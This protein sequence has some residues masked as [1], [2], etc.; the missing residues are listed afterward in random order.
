MSSYSA[1][2]VYV[3]SVRFAIGRD[4]FNSLSILTGQTKDFKNK[5]YSSLLDPLHE[6]HNVDKNLESFH[7]VS[8]DK[9]LNKMLSLC[10]RQ[11]VGLSSLPL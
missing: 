6:K 2:R 1:R 4:G 5:I 3:Q 8:F 7:V 10:G 9:A 11:V